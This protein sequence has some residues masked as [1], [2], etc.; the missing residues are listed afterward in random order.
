MMAQYLGTIIEKTD[1][2]LVII[3]DVIKPGYIISCIIEN[4]I[5]VAPRKDNN[6]STEECTVMLFYDNWINT[7]F[8]N[9]KVGDKIGID[10]EPITK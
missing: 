5:M 3:P 7:V 8:S 10:Y 2:T 9:Y 1:N 6:L 4:D